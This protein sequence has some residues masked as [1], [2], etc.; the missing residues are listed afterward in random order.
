MF[1]HP[2]PEPVEP[3]G[4]SAAAPGEPALDRRWRAATAGWRPSSIRSAGAERVW[5][6]VRHAWEALVAPPAGGDDDGPVAGAGAPGRSGTGSGHRVDDLLTVAALLALQERFLAVAA[7]EP[8]PTEVPDP[9]LEGAALDEDEA[10]A[11]VRRTW[12]IDPADAG[13][14]GFAAELSGFLQDH[15]DELAE[16]V[17]EQLVDRRGPTQLFAELWS[18]EHEDELEP[19]DEQDAAPPFPLSTDDIAWI[20]SGVPGPEKHTAW[21]WLTR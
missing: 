20:V 5:A 2:A 15:L 21:E 1:S 9:R 13:T 11:V 7:G 10:L 6:W 14:D 18:L 17:R 8:V 12:E 16:E 3:T 4:P 19:A